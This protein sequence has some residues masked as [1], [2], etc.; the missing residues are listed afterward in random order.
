MAFVGRNALVKVTGTP[1][2][3]ILRLLPPAFRR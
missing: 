1:D 2:S 3:F